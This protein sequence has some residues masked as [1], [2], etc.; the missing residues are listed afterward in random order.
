MKKTYAIRL[1]RSS[2]NHN[3]VVKGS[4]CFF[5]KLLGATSEEHGASLGVGAALEEVESLAADLGLSE[6]AACSKL[7][8]AQIQTR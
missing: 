5:Q 6:R 4:L 2:N 3:R 7:I 1:A 8:F